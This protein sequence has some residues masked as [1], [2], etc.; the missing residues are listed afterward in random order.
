MKKKNNIKLKRIS[1]VLT[2]A[3]MAASAAGMSVSAN[4]A[5]TTNALKG[6]KTVKTAGRTAKKSKSSGINIENS[7]EQYIYLVG[8]DAKPNDTVEVALRTHTGNTCNAFDVDV[9]FD[10]RLELDKVVGASSYAQ[11]DKDGKKYITI[12]NFQTGLGNYQDDTDIVKLYFKVPNQAENDS[13]DIRF[14]QITTFAN[15][16]EEYESYE[17][18]NTAINVT[19]G[20]E[21]KVT[22]L[23]LKSV[24]SM[25]GKYATVD[26][27]SQSNNRCESFDI[28]V[29]YDPR[30]TIDEDNIIIKSG[31]GSY[32]VY[33]QD[34]KNY[35][36]LV[37]FRIDGNTYTDGESIMGLNFLIP[38]DAEADEEYDV[39][40]AEVTTFADENG[41][42]EEYELT[43][44]SVSVYAKKANEKFGTY[45]LFEK[46]DPNTGQVLASVMGVRGD[47]NGDNK[48]T[49]A[50]AA[51]LS[52][53][54]S[55]RNLDLLSEECKVFVD[56]NNDGKANA[57]DAMEIAKHKASRSDTW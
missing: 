29:E 48:N 56:V 10:A 25:A 49:A 2:T 3:L 44:G 45:K 4:T 46:I 35:V 23:T 18:A 12:V 36:A 19:G 51:Y 28:V 32:S 39:R 38:E 6:T 26:L 34:G 41:D 31:V 57:M 13:Y 55:K 40:I 8:N 14:S 50:D 21:K 5:Q 42:I 43:D 9:E 52:Q 30:L 16:D 53:A 15:E 33:E 1:A 11:Y 24:K 27:V 22:G 54:L 17:V 7:S 20:V 47:A 37:G